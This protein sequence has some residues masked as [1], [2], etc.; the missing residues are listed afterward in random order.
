[1]RVAQSK[2]LLNYKKL[3]SLNFFE[4]F[5]THSQ[6]GQKEEVAA[7]IQMCSLARFFLLEI[8]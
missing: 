8:G 1:L 5:L 4:L 2:S 3:P 6:G 7:A